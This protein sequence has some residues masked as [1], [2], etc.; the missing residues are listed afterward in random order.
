M[1]NIQALHILKC[2]IEILNEDVTELK[3]IFKGI[4]SSITNEKIKNAFKSYNFGQTLLL[5]DE[6]LLRKSEFKKY[7][8]LRDLEKFSNIQINT[9]Y[10][11]DEI[12]SLLRVSVLNFCSVKDVSDNVLSYVRHWDNNRRISVTM[13]RELMEKLKTDRTT[14]FTVSLSTKD[15]KLGYYIQLTFFEYHLPIDSG[16]DDWDSDSES[17][18]YDY[19]DADEFSLWAGFDGDVEA[20]RGHYL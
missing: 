11:I 8:F 20:W 9:P 19:E 6:E 7:Y 1:N 3:Q 5:A 10:T 15:A 12:K 18:Y 13:D 16:Y 2:A 4:E 17:S 14:L